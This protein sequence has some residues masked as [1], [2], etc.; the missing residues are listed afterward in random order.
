VGL[1]GWPYYGNPYAYGYPYNPYGYGYPV[2][3]YPG[4]GYVGPIPNPNAPPNQIAP[5]SGVITNDVSLMIHTP[6]ESTV[7]INGIKTTQTGSSR[8]FVS[9]GLVPGRTYTYEIRALWTDSDGKTKDHERRIP[10]QAGEKR[11]IDFTLPSP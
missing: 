11:I 8:E 7:W 10:V 6:P 3:P 9:T 1:Y 4:P 2:S 5:A